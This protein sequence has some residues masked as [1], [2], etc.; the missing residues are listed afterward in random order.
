VLA[1]GFAVLAL[2][3]LRPNHGLG[4]LLT[5]A[6]ACS[7]GMTLLTLP[8][9]LAAGGRRRAARRNAQGPVRG[10]REDAA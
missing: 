7:Y 10:L 2:S 4:L 8:A 1:A 9:L 3:T 5:L 6:V